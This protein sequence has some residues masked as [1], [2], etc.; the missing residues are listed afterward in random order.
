MSEHAIL[1]KY[2]LAQLAKLTDDML[3]LRIVNDN[4][5]LKKLAVREAEVIKLQGDISLL[6]NEIRELIQKLAAQ[7]DAQR[8]KN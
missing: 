1:V 2:H 4:E 5:L 8:H 6:T 7:D 3:Q